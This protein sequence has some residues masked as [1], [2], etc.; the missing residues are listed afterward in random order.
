MAI[1]IDPNS[2]INIF[3]NF[4]ALI[5]HQQKLIMNQ[6]QIQTLEKFEKST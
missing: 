5:I 4:K 3:L 2:F 1:I 6:K